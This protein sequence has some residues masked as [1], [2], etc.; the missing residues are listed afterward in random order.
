MGPAHEHEQDQENDH[1]LTLRDKQATRL[2]VPD[3]E[4]RAGQV[5]GASTGKGTNSSSMRFQ[6]AP[7]T[8]N[9]DG[10]QACLRHALG[11]TRRLSAWG[12]AKGY[13]YC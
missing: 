7:N 13:T 11:R 3:H 6:T 10:D 8:S 5:P 9:N 4:A 2:Q 1:R 12:D